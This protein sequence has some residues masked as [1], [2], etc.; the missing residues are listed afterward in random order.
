MQATAPSNVLCAFDGSFAIGLLDALAHVQSSGQD[1]LLIAYDSEY[2]APLYQCRPIP[3]AGAIALLFRAAADTRTDARTL[4][5]ISVTLQVAATPPDTLPQATLETLR[6]TIPAF[7]GLPLLAALSSLPDLLASGNGKSHTV[8]LDYLEH[9]RLH[10]T[11][12][13]AGAGT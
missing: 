10:V 12:T 11:L 9:T 8:C 3:D 2:P 1:C 5:R 13:P 6:Q 4:A 7:R